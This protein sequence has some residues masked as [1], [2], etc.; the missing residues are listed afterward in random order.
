MEDYYNTN[1]DFKR[2]VDRHC[3]QYGCTVEEALRE[4]LVR[5]VYLY[6]KEQDT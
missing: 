5:Q 3:T 1:P 2:Y 6:Y 4:E